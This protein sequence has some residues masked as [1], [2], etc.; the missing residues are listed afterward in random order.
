MCLAKHL[1]NVLC[2]AKQEYQ[3]RR[4]MVPDA[5]GDSSSDSYHSA[6]DNT[7]LVRD[8]ISYHDGFDIEEHEDPADNSSICFTIARIPLPILQSIAALYNQPQGT[9]L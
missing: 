9:Y 1:G 6:G 5:E 3:S 2:R 4:S 7:M 8:G